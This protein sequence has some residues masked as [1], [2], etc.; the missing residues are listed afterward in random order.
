M[1]LCLPPIM[2][3]QVIYGPRLN[4][5]G[6]MNGM[7]NP[8]SRQN[9]VFLVSLGCPKNFVDTETMAGTLL[10]GGYDLTFDQDEATITLVNTCAFLPSAR[11]ES[12][13]A[14]EEALA[15]KKIKPE[16]R[17]VAVCGCLIQWDRDREFM[18]KYPEVDLWSGVDGVGDICRSLNACHDKKLVGD[19]FSPSYLYDENTARLQLTVPHVAYLKIADGCDNRCSYCSIPKIRGGLR[20]RSIASC[21]KEAENLLNAGVKE[22]VVIAQDVTAFGMDNE[23]GENLTGLLR[24][25][26][27]LSGNFWIR[28]LYTHPAHYTDELVEFLSKSKHVLPYLDIPLQ[29]ISSRILHEMGRKI[30]GDSTRRLLNKLRDSIPGVAIRTTF[31]TGLPGETEF[32]YQELYDFVREFKFDRLGVFEYSAEPGTPAAVMSN[33]VAHEIAAARASAIMELQQQISLEHN[34]SLVGHKFQVIVDDKQGKK[35]IAR[36]YFDAPE[37]D[38]YIEISSIR[39]LKEGR[40][41]TVEITS[42]DIYDLR[43]RV[44]L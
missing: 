43:G 20:S 3:L 39:P 27:E 1:Q 30:D 26:D 23:S 34:R 40:F 33:Q 25:L 2:I 12:Y 15:W 4:K 41:Y 22:L 11:E 16:C 5:A 29:H 18:T 35:G 31:I 14:I 13:A 32:E 44:I 19:A 17:K 8:Q 42:A 24:K 10:Q 38:N 36:A 28:L 7:R 21:V 37:I 6:I 9:S